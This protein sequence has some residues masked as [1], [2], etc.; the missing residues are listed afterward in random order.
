M[1]EQHGPRNHKCSKCECK[2]AF[3]SQLKEHEYAYVTL[4]K[5]VCTICK[6]RYK[7]VKGL[8]VHKES[9]VPGFYRCGKCAYKAKKFDTLHEHERCHHG[10][11]R[12]HCDHCPQVFKFR[13][14]LK[15]HLAKHQW[16]CDK[17]VRDC[18]RN[19]WQSVLVFAWSWS[20][21]SFGFL[22]QFICALP[23]VHSVMK[24]EVTWVLQPIFVLVL[25][26]S[27]TLS[28]PWTMMDQPISRFDWIVEVTSWSCNSN[29]LEK[30]S[31]Q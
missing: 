26:F 12:Y 9:H 25:C 8:C 5:F 31:S 10:P 13:Q 24:K 18:Y 19:K 14:L 17:N 23:Y 27:G 22:V 7:S 29:L 2:F 16:H 21:F 15:R 20:C 3:A 1:L 30:F 6:A 4:G 28:P 11:P